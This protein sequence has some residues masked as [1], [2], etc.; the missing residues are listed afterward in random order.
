MDRPFYSGTGYFDEAIDIIKREATSVDQD[1]IDGVTRL[2]K[3]FYFNEVQHLPAA[4]FERE[5]KL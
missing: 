5:K 3:L 1:V 4:S 2:A